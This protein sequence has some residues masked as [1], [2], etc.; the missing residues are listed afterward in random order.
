M[1]KVNELIEQFLFFILTIILYFL[2]LINLPLFDEPHGFL[3]MNELSDFSSNQLAAA[4]LFGSVIVCIS[5]GALMMKWLP[6]FTP[7]MAANLWATT[8]FLIWVDS[9][10]ALSVQ[11]QS[12]HYLVLLGFGL[13]F[14]YLFFFTLYYLD[15][16]RNPIQEPKKTP[17]KY[18]LVSY[19]LGT[20]MVF[21]LI[22]SVRLLFNSFGYPELQW[23]LAMGFCALC[24]L[25]YLLFLFL[26]RSNGQN[27]DGLSRAGRLFFSFWFFALLCAGIGQHYFH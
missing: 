17:S 7:G 9:M 25:N 4:S 16:P 27:I 1:R 19:W 3:V 6:P 24:F 8:F 12:F 18:K 14:L 13:L 11:S 26:R 21:Y 15:L 23:P 20:W 22:V 2:F 5:L 10:F